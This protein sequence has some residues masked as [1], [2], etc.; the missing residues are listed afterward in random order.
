MVNR[1]MS[2]RQVLALVRRLARREELILVELPGRGKASHRL[3]RL[4]DAGGSEVV[5][6]GVTDHPGDVS[7]LV[8]RRL[9][10]RLEPVFGKDWTEKER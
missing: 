2:A 8:L 3:Y 4:V 9:E 7:W 1:R 5:R 10:E 6:F